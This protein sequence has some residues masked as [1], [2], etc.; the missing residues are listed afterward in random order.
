M[1]Y[2]IAEPFAEACALGMKYEVG[3]SKTRDRICMTASKERAERVVEALEAL[4]AT[5]DL[6]RKLTNKTR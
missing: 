4:D 1:K 2:F 5:K 6:L 3:D